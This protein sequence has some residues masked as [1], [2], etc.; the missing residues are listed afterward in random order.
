[1]TITAQDVG[2]T[3]SVIA[4]VIAGFVIARVLT[5]PRRD[6]ERTLDDVQR[7]LRARNAELERRHLTIIE[8]ADRHAR[9]AAAAKAAQPRDDD[10]RW[11]PSRTKIPEHRMPYDRQAFVAAE[12]AAFEA[13]R[14]IHRLSASTYPAPAPPAP[15][16]PPRPPA[17]PGH[18]N[19]LAFY[20][21]ATGDY[22][23]LPVPTEHDPR[24]LALTHSPFGTQLTAE[25][26]AER[27]RSGG[28][29]AV[30]DLS[31]VPIT[32]AEL[33]AADRDAQRVNVFRAVRSARGTTHL[34]YQKTPEADR[35]VTLRDHYPD[36]PVAEPEAAV[37]PTAIPTRI[38]AVDRYKRPDRRDVRIEADP[39]VPYS[40]TA[41]GATTY[42]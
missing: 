23:T 24:G 17:P 18:P 7:A 16:R 42:S 28:A 5:R 34:E 35:L 13:R 20:E 29:V 8:M 6:L 40:R 11:Q 10:G 19:S 39:A 9:D 3:L 22:P 25:Q 31:D 4:C 21:W 37:K 27:I 38:D 41:L 36:A 15:P 26:I 2:V 1:M 32:A 30:G 33:E 14:S 12:V